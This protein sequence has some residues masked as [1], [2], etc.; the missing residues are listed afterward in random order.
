[1][2]ETGKDTLLT[3]GEIP[4]CVVWWRTDIR[5]DLMYY[6]ENEKEGICLKTVFRK[7]KSSTYRIFTLTDED[8]ETMI[9]PRII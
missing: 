8:I 4:T 3:G 5:A 7:G 1:M 6:S 9:L 2:T